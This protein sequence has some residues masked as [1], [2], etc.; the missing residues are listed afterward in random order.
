MSTKYPGGF[1]TKSPTAPTSTAAPGV[2]TLEQQ[3]QYQKAGTW[4][5]PPSPY[6]EDWF[7][8]WLYAGN[9]STQTITNGINFSA[10]G[11]LVWIKQRDGADS[12]QFFTDT[13]RG[14]AYILTSAT[15]SGGSYPS[16]GNQLTGFGTV[17]FATTGFSLD[18]A[19]YKNQNTKPFVS[20]SFARRQ[21]FFDIVTYTG[22]SVSGREINHNLGSTPGCIIVKCTTNVTAWRVYHRSLVSTGSGVSAYL[23]LDSTAAVDQQTRCWG[24]TGQPTAT[25]FG[26]G[27]DGDLNETGQ[28]YVAYLF[29]H[30]AGGFGLT[31]TDNVISCGS[32]TGNGS[33]TGPVV[34]LGYE[35]QWLM[36]KRATGTANG[37]WL[38]L[39]VMRGFNV[40]T[41]NDLYANLSNAEGTG[42]D[43]AEPQA[44][45]F[46][47]K[48]S[49]SGVN[50]NTDTYIYM[51]IRRGPMKVPTTGTS[52]FSPNSTSGTTGTQ[53]TTGFPVD[54]Q[55][56]GI[57][58]GNVYNQRSSTRL[59]GVNTDGSSNS[60]YLVTSNTN[61]EAATG[62]VTLNWG[63]T[64]YQVS[65]LNS[66]S[67]IIDWNFQRAPGFFDVICWTGDG[68]TNQRISH[69]LGV[70]PELII[71]KGRSTSSVWYTYSSSLTSPQY[72]YVQLSGTNAQVTNGAML[73]GTSVPTSTDFGLNS[74]GTGSGLSGV[75]M[76]AYLFATCANV[77]KVGSYTGTGA[78]QTISC[79]FT[80]GARF[81]LIKRTDSTG[82]W[83]VW[84][85]ARGMV[86]GTDPSLLLNDTAAEV[87][88]N[89]IYTTTGGFQIVSTASGINAS[90]GTYIYLAIA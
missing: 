11:G 44:T 86:A 70:A 40:S 76:V 75:T 17:T 61:A 72:S 26:V 38:M 73:W 88:A 20:W 16:T 8:T 66:G 18:S 39:D 15:F 13:V 46:Q 14:G 80:G 56:L 64:G 58:A 67:P 9:G 34:T 55:L 29:A 21:K 49:S 5:S 57:N 4:P 48:S 25:T 71:T 84:D 69:N 74:S 33:S 42:L 53:I 85:T 31:G 7:S 30:D 32:Y 65:S 3:A 78:T 35:P 10:N 87:N 50:A 83:Y 90:G 59:T 45:G 81:V 23:R 19:F 47:I 89:S 1:I 27:N 28:T 63:S 77:S 2:W 52:V 51:A 60:Q 43:L 12:G 82:D 36:I 22:D 54:W 68:T 79:G 62:S 41:D 37:N 6:I 24:F